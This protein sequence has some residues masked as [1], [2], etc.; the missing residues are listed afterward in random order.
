M[1]LASK[2]EALQ[3]QAGRLWQLTT[4]CINPS[5]W[6]IIDFLTRTFKLSFNG[7]QSC[8]HGFIV[9]NFFAALISDKS[10][11]LH[12][13]NSFVVNDIWHFLIHN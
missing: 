2:T 7:W 8:C 10:D 13:N 9:V 4:L 1:P 5:S 11:T 6:N 12:D 3:W